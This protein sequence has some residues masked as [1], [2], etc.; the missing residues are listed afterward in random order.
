V[1][2]T[3]FGGIRLIIPANCHQALICQPDNEHHRK[4]VVLNSLKG[5]FIA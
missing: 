3:L 1:K 5:Y 2:Y 4:S